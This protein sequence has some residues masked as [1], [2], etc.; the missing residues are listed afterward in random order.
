MLDAQGLGAALRAA[1]HDL[2]RLETLDYYAVP[3]DGGDFHRY[4]AG[5]DVPDQARKD[6]WHDRLRGER[7]RGV[8]RHRVY[9]AREP[10]SPY[11]RF[12][13]E[14][15]HALNADLEEIRVLPHSRIPQ[16]V[17]LADWWMVD[18]RDVLLMHYDS[19]GRFTGAEPA[20]S[21]ETGR[22]LA[23]RTAAWEAAEPFTAWWAAHPQY[24]RHVSVA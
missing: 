15:G 13:C 7:E 14:W 8:Y 5:E 9:V 3:S 21:A 20:A 11:A 24:H 22:Y 16:G 6:A 18:R 2:F 1:E 12:E 4:L 17:D 19:E 23:A 10:L